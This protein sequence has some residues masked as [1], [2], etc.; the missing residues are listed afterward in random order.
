MARTG[1]APGAGPRP[2]QRRLRFGITRWTQAV[3]FR[4]GTNGVSANGVSANCHFLDRDLLGTPVNVLLFLYS[5]KY[6]GVPFSSICHEF[7]Y[8]RSGPIS[9]D[10]I[11]R[12]PNFSH[13]HPLPREPPRTS[14]DL[15]AARTP[16]TSSYRELSRAWAWVPVSVKT[17]ILLGKPWSYNPTAETALQ[18][19]I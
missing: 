2:V 3:T 7:H 15:P 14:A 17:K 19:L 18:P 5:Q 10:P 4:R 6:Q 1:R 12:Q 8:F 11:C 13:P 16:S 9:A